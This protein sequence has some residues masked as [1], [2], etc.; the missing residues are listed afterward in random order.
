MSG[1]SRS[2]ERAETGSPCTGSACQ[3]KADAVKLNQHA[4][5]TKTNRAT[6]RSSCD[7]SSLVEAAPYCP[8]FASID[9][10]GFSL[11]VAVQLSAMVTACS[12][13]IV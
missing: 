1:A 8:V 3:A 7:D 11:T 9:A 2:P 6:P 12:M 5:A 10:L 13:R 4:K